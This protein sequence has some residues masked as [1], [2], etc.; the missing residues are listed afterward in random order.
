MSA[1]WKALI[2]LLILAAF[3]LLTLVG[4]LA[5]MTGSGAFLGACVGGAL[6]EIAQR[7]DRRSR[8]GHL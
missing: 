3:V 5:G 8:Q 6:F 1:K 4:H 2:A 7:A